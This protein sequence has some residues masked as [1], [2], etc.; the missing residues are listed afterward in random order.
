MSPHLISAHLS[1]SAARFSRK[2]L[3]P[4]DGPNSLLKIE[5]PAFGQGPYSFQPPRMAHVLPLLGVRINTPDED[6]YGAGVGE[7]KARCIGDMQVGFERVGLKWAVI[8]KYWSL[9][10]RLALNSQCDCCCLA[11]CK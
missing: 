1:A 4:Q 10:W 6:A 2:C 7:M 3:L 11:L 9:V 8:I 5:I